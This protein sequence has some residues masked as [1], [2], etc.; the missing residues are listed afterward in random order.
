MV[1]PAGDGA[2]TEELMGAHRAL[3]DVAAGDAERALQIER[4]K[5]LAMLDGARDVRCVFG[6]HFDA[7]VA[8]L[9]FDVVP[10]AIRQ[11]IRR[12]LDE[13][14]EDVFAGRGDCAVDAGG[15]RD[16]E[17][18]SLAGAAVFGVV[19]GAFEVFE[20][21]ADVHRAVVLW[22]DAIAGHARESRRFAESKIH[23]CGGG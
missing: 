8:E 18:R 19:V 20:R 6:E 15:H 12:V 4:R 22:A 7:A 3:H 11:F 10:V 5:D 2:E 14:A 23:F 21:W 1:G 13:H 17:D 9:F 16:F